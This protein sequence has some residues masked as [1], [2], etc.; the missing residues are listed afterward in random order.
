M[1]VC[2]ISWLMPNFLINLLG[3]YGVTASVPNFLI[4][5]LRVFGVTANL[6]SFLINLLALEA[7]K[8]SLFRIEQKCMVKARTCLWQK[9]RAC[10]LYNKTLLA[11]INMYKYVFVFLL[12]NFI[13]YVS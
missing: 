3:V 1:Q 13:C 6:P 9:P 12:I 5:L 2:Q 8:M 10:N 7:I 11:N 4:N